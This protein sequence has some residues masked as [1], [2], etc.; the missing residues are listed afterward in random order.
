VKTPGVNGEHAAAVDWLG[1]QKGSYKGFRY[2]I[3]IVANPKL[4]DE[5]N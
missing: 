5:L 2:F 4:E 3:T 1:K